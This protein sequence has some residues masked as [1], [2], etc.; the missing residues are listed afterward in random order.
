MD[1]GFFREYAAETRQTT[2][3]SGP[4]LGA[5]FIQFIRQIVTCEGNHIKLFLLGARRLGESQ[6]T[7]LRGERNYIYMR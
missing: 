3:W 6:K 5:E 1:P 2:A 4:P 7:L